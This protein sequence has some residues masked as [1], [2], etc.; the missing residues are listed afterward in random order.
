VTIA[1]Y[2]TPSGVM[3]D[4]VGV[5]PDIVVEG[6]YTGKLDDDEQ[7]KRATKEVEALLVKV[8]D[9]VAK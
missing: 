8:P 7:L 5:E 4:G 6:K 9:K 1:K 2:Y 3:I